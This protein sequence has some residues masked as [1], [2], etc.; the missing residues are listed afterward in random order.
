MSQM[1]PYHGEASLAY[2]AA[3]Q[4][5]PSD[6]HDLERLFGAIR[7]RWRILLAIA[8]GFFVLAGLITI[9]T[10][11][12]YTTTV[13]LLVGRPGT[14]IAP[15]GNDTAL[16]VLNALVLQ[17]GAQSAETLAELAQGHDIAS[18]VI[19]QLSLKTSAGALLGRVSVKPIVNTSLLN[20]S[21]KWRDPNSSANI[22]N[23]F[24][25]AF[26]DQ[27]REFVRSEAVAALG[28]LAN[29]LPN[30]RA[31]MQSAETQL[32]QFQA[33]HGYLDATAHEQ[34]INARLGSI[35][36]HMDQLSVD[37]NEATALLD[38][39]NS[40]LATLSST[41]DS[42]KDVAAN[43]VSTDLRTKLSDV[44]TQLA[45]AEQK[46]TP[47]H[48]A[49]IAL[50]QQRAALL[51]QIVAQPAAVVSQ[52]TVAPNPLYQSLQ[53]QA[54]TYRA[55]IEGD[56][57]QIQALE[58]Q[59][60]AYR[61]AMKTLPQQAVAFGSVQEESKRAAN[62]YNALQQK[63]SDALVAKSTA[64]SDIIVVQSASADS[65]VKSPSLRTNLA[66]AVVV[67]L[68]L[69]LAVIYILDLLERRTTDRDFTA[70]LGL[71]VIARIP[72]LS[73]TNPRMLPWVQSLTLEAFLHL[74]VTL[75]LR[76]KRPI[77]SL[78]IL[79]ARRG[80][81]KSTVAY[82]LAKSMAALQPGILLIDADLRQPTLHEKAGC[83]NDVGLNDVL[84]GAV[85]L[86]DAV[87]HLAP[88]LD[89]LTSRGNEP[90]PI[91]LLQGTFEGL[92]EQAGREYGMVIVDAPAL[93]A[94]SDALLVASEVDGSLIVV[95]ADRGDERDTQRAIAQMGLIGVENILGVV[96]NRDSTATADFY[97][98][99]AKT[100]AALTAGLA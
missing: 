96:V 50:R 44:E 98:Y 34:D 12:T 88:G 97:G 63:Y 75:R 9:L 47:A 64:I 22:A 80:E 54:A 82:N 78:A 4:G 45:E 61:P 83:M 85:P 26:V 2:S 58:A 90:N 40:Q 65:A 42:A 25:T 41:V 16:P 7:R 49:V 84:H 95:S 6:A 38:S 8:G 13:R 24:A 5:Q 57:G 18:K 86:D 51:A 28:F 19:D 33:T 11:K 71:P 92:L 1:T 91:A 32:A 48:P 79:S 52:T 35:D 23:A 3:P 10:P 31:K 89:V 100:N 37:K 21:V 72:P 17:S 29:E 36:Q 77:K 87:Q 93:A 76:N 81:G 53:S 39:V 73:T 60:K 43:P 67:G 74:C 99:F 66:I 56:Q 59:R 20:L 55:R 46:Y 69:G 15:S 70:L 14:D 62:V 68:L 30:A 94:V 27:E